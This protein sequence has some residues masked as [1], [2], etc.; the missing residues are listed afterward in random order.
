[1][2]AESPCSQFAQVKGI[3]L[4]VNT[5]PNLYSLAANAQLIPPGPCAKFLQKT[6]GKLQ[7][8]C[9]TADDTLCAMRQAK[10][11]PLYVFFNPLI[12]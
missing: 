7:C 6:L 3:S 2:E 10:S 5:M 8:L 1:M 9:S 12:M 4:L 11:A